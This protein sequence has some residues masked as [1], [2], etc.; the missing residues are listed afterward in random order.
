LPSG[1]ASTVHG[2]SSSS[3]TPAPSSTSRATLLGGGVTGGHDDVDVDA[4]LGRPRLRHLLE[5]QHGTAERRRSAVEL[6][7]DRAVHILPSMPEVLAKGACPEGAD[8]LHVAVDG[9][10]DQPA[11]H[12][13]G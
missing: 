7:V 4:V 12:E 9:H 6:D 10:G 3:R 5:Q 1:S 13:D 11:D 2:R 8:Q